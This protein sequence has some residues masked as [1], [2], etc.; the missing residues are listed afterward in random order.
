MV[1]TRGY[2]RDEAE[3]RLAAQLPVEDKAARSH[4]VIDN[5]GNVEELKEK[6]KKLA[7]WL[8]ESAA[9]GGSR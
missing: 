6:V 5:D 9:I 8:K 7:D 1:E 3:A 4:Y 2:T